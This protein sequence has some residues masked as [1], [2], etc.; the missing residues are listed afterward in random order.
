MSAARSQGHSFIHAGAE[1]QQHVLGP[2][3]WRRQG[4]PIQLETPDRTGLPG[5]AET[6][7]RHEP[8]V[9]LLGDETVVL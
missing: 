2:A 9:L 8:G 3:L 5:E 4:V 7:Q 1:R 6:H